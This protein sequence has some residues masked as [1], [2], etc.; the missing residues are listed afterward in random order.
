MLHLAVEDEEAAGGQ[1]VPLPLRLE[2][3]L[4]VEHLHA[5]RP[6]GLVRL[7]GSACL[8][9]DEREAQA[10]FLDERPS[11]TLVPRGQ[12]LAHGADLVGEGEGELAAADRMLHW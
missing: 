5:D 11:G 3:D 4:A 6:V 2:L 7:D 1:R 10:A 9:A 12:L 8:H